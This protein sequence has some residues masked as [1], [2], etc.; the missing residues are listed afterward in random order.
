MQLFYHPAETLEFKLPASKACLKPPQF[1]SRLLSIV[2]IIIPGN[3]ESLDVPS[4]KFIHHERD[5]LEL[6]IS[7]FTRSYVDGMRVRIY[8]SG[9][10]SHNSRC[11]TLVKCSKAFVFEHVFCNE[12]YS[13]QR[14]FPG[15]S[16]G[17][18]EPCF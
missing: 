16:F 12:G 2:I 13:L 17:A 8:L 18:L 7:F 14:R 3:L 6:P 9:S 4:Y 15:P 10:Y 5:R 1:C 11:D